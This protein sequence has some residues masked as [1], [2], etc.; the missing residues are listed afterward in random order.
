LNFIT[1]K[2]TE[3]LKRSLSL[4]D[5]TGWITGGFLSSGTTVSSRTA[6]AINA[7]YTSCKIL[8]ESV[9]SI[10]FEVIKKDGDSRI[11]VN[12][13]VK[14]LLGVSPDPDNGVVA[15]SYW[16]AVL[17][18]IGTHGNS[19]S[20]IQ[21]NGGGEAERIILML[22]WECWPV[23]IEGE[24]WYQTQNYGMLRPDDILHFKGVSW[25]GIVGL[26]PITEQN[27][28]MSLAEKINQYSKVIYG[29]KVPGYISSNETLK[30][31][32]LK[33]VAL[34]W[35]SQITGD[36]LGGTPI[37]GDGMKYNTI[38]LNPTDIDYIKTRNITD[39]NIYAMY[40]IPP[41]L[42]QDYERATFSNAEQQDL[43][44]IKGTIMPYL[45]SFEQEITTK[46]FPIKNRRSSK[47]LVAKFN[48]NSVLRGDFKTRTEGY[49]LMF[50]NGL[51][52]RDEIRAKEDMNPTEN[53]KVYWQMVNMQ[54]EEQALNPPEE[55]TR[56]SEDVQKLLETV[57]S[58]GNGKG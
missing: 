7:V 22:P 53:G 55:G 24:I 28:I 38:N 2:I 21:R 40:R 47:P 9:S 39:Q 29:K 56:T 13:N 31:E 15:S 45:K 26:S 54:P 33:Q 51:M 14:F 57:N 8:G 50:R 30:T 20:Y 44:F 10:A 32:Q 11:Q 5:P 19:Y 17:I 23:M 49:A 42:A 4:S 48:V 43:V 52:N 25:G 36:E 18:H 27:D 12:N 58:N 37:L 35:E 46:L 3:W 16:Q 1:R 41:T 6:L 34:M